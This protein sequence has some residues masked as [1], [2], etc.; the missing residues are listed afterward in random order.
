METQAAWFP[1][2]CSV[3]NM[4]TR[5]YSYMYIEICICLDYLGKESEEYGDLERRE[6]FHCVPGMFLEG[7]AE[8][9]AQAEEIL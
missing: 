6:N 3:T 1:S 7:Q 5:L 4:L 9:G 8:E 2:S